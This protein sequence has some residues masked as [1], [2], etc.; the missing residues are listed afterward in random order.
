MHLKRWNLSNKTVIVSVLNQEDKGHKHT[1]TH[2]REKIII[3]LNNST[4]K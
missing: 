1:Y 3:E 4:N 2:K